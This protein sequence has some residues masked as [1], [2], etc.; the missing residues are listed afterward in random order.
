L[1]YAGKVGTGYTAQ[2]LA[3]LSQRLRRSERSASPFE[4][5]ADLPR[6]G[7]HRVQPR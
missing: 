7:V 4:P 1:R 6:R 3:V 5:A 2:T